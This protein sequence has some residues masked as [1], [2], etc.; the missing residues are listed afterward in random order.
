[1][2]SAILVAIGWNLIRRG[3]RETHKNVMLTA[4]GFA[5]A[6]FILYMTRTVVSGN[7]AFGGPDY[8]R[9][10]YLIFLWTHI[11]L[12]TTSAVFGIVTITLA[13]RERFSKHRR[14]GRWT[15][16]MWFIT[17]LTGLAVYILLYVLYPGDVGSIWDAVLR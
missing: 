17:A 10:P 9:I 5:L 15:A 3:K 4:A 2:T 16:V 12:S 1:M 13:F 14:F 6:F 8:M 7:L 11:I